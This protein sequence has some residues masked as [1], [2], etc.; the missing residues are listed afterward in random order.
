MPYVSFLKELAEELSISELQ[1][2]FLQLI[3]NLQNVERG[4][5]WIKKGDR[6][7]CIEAEGVESQN[8]IG[9]TMSTK[10]TSI[11]GW[12]LENREMTIAE[13]GVDQRHYTGVEENFKLKSKLILCFPLFLTN[14]E[15][16]GALQ[17]IDTSSGGRRLNLQPENMKILQ[18]MIDIG[19]IALSNA[20]IQHKRL[21]QVKEL[22]RTIDSMYSGRFIIGVSQSFNEVMELVDSYAVT[23]YPI[24]IYGE[25][26]TGKELIAKEIHRRSHRRDMP[27][28]VQNC[29][30]I[31]GQLLE[32]ELFGYVKGA[33]TGASQNKAGLFEAA[34]GG[35]VFL[36]E[37]GEME[38]GLQAKMLRAL[39]E[40]E[41]KPLGSPQSRKVNMRIISATNKNLEKAIADSEFRQDLFYRLNVL[42]LHLPPLRERKEDIPFL[43]E[44]FINREAKFMNCERK[45][46]SPEAMKLIRA[47]RW[48]GNIREL[49]NFIRQLMVLCHDDVVEAKHLPGYIQENQWW[50]EAPF[51]HVHD[52]Y[53]P[54]RE[55]GC[56]VSSLEME[57]L[58]WN[59]VEGAYAKFVLEKCEGNISRAAKVANLNRSTF[60][61]R[62]SKLGVK[63]IPN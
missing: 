24:L 7:Q 42:P 49:E 5:I 47:Y 10:D 9:M 6:I 12:V 34:D 22:T 21:K 38:Y 4:S 20:L 29:S 13:G 43:A 31:P 61:S 3:L 58:T 17:V 18:D 36:D 48:P 11:V 25:S 62:L 53:T 1:K 55:D 45:K 44:H 50:C 8:V 33:F 59:E 39:E 16:Y 46:I 19:S 51:E 23:D 40:N 57:G 35:T 60:D 28:M 56:A 37:L 32:S 27:L 52:N 2:R 26:G 30:A 41:I 54:F 14:G 15:I 63:K